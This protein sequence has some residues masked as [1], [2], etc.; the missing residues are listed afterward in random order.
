MIRYCGSDRRD[1]RIL[2][3]VVGEYR[4]IT[5]FGFN[6]DDL[7]FREKIRVPDRRQ[8]DIRAAVDDDRDLAFGECLL[9]ELRQSR[10]M[11]LRKTLVFFIDEDL[12]QDKEVAGSGPQ[13][14][15]LGDFLYSQPQCFPARFANRQVKE[16]SDVH[17]ACRAE[18]KFRNGEQEITHIGSMTDLR[19]THYGEMK[20]SGHKNGSSLRLRL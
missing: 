1:I 15:R 6:G 14:Q 9:I 20:I 17:E 7:S 16:M 5:R 4:K 19:S 13:S 8:T 18:T 2:G 3:G 12:A 11:R 10:R